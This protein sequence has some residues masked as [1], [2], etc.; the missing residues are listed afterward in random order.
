MLYEV[1]APAV[2]DVLQ[3]HSVLGEQATGISSGSLTLEQTRVG[4]PRQEGQGRYSPH[5]HPASCA[6]PI[7]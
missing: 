4:T 1:A 5:S 7:S 3:V 2:G 6:E